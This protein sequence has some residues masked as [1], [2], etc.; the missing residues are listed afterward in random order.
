[1]TVTIPPMPPFVVPSP[2]LA[3]MLPVVDVAI[4]TVPPLYPVP[5]RFIAPLTITAP[6][7]L[8]PFKDIERPLDEDVAITLPETL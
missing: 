2:P 8:I 4:V 5:K 3:Y 6:N 7:T 1:M